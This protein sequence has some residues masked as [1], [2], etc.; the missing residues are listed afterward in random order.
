MHSWMKQKENY[1]LTWRYVQKPTGTHLLQGH[2]KW[3]EQGFDELKELKK[4]DQRKFVKLNFIVWI[5]LVV[6]KRPG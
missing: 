6:L 3:K 4:L 1:V 2:R 5:D